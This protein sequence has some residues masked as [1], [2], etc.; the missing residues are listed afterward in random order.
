MVGL[1]ERYTRYDDS[2]KK[3]DWLD[4]DK[5]LARLSAYTGHTYEL[6]KSLYDDKNDKVLLY[7]RTDV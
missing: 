6:V 7:K 3:D 2:I 5:V 1:A 4:T